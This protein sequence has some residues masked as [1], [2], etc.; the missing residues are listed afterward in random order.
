MTTIS[1]LNAVLFFLV[2]LWAWWSPSV[3]Q[4]RSWATS[5]A[6]ATTALSVLGLLVLPPHNEWSFVQPALVC[7]ITWVAVALSS[8]RRNRCSTFSTILWLSS[9][10]SLMAVPLSPRWLA[11]LWVTMTILTW[12]E[13]RRH[14][15]RASSM[16]ALYMGVSTLL[17]TG[18]I[19]SGRTDTL[20][21]TV[22]IALCIREACF[23]FQSWFLSFVEDLP[24]GLVVAFTSP[25]LGTFFHVKILAGHL[26]TN[27]QHEIATLGIA[28]ALFGAALATVQPKLKRVLGYLIISQTGLVAFGLENASTV[29]NAGALAAWLVVGLGSAG[30]AMT[31]EALETRNGE[32]V[33]L[34]NSPGNFEKMPILATSFLL[35]GM[36]MVGLPGSLGFIS[37]DL[38]VQGSVEEFP[39]LG[40][41]L[42]VITA[43]NAISVIKCLL[44]LFAGSPSCPCPIDL[45]PR[46]K[47]AIS[48]VLAPIFFFGIF[49]SIV[50]SWL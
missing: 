10:T 3:R 32:P 11:S 13:A 35:T 6:A 2:G 39:I 4:A 42:I 48:V 34:E 33:D 43:L 19:Y 31:I 36:A 14:S 5:V 18:S 25:Q 49:P 9:I 23:P 50:L 44:K 17:L 45:E 40:F 8:L 47:W 28:T 41:I 21:M 15:R 46:E 37:E 38:L 22:A 20:L 1:I 27:Y 26:P 30:F 29:A 16:F 24:M 7:I 12:L